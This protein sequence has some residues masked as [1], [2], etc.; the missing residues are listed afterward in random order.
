MPGRVAESGR[1]VI[2]NNFSILCTELQEAT[3][4]HVLPYPYRGVSL[5]ETSTPMLKLIHQH[6]TVPRI[7]AV[8][9]LFNRQL[10]HGPFGLSLFLDDLAPSF[11]R[12]ENWR[13]RCPQS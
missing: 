3:S 7:I 1:L 12:L 4:F 5:R 2:E 6:K 9:P 8:G 11:H 13:Q 10:P